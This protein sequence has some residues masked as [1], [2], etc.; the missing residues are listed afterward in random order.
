MV[1]VK[2]TTGGQLFCQGWQK[3][4]LCVVLAKLIGSFLR[5]TKDAERP[6]MSVQA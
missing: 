2:V 4:R 3:I 1:T 5:V 6:G